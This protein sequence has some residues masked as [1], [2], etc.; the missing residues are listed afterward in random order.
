VVFEGTGASIRSFEVIKGVGAVNST[1]LLCHEGNISIK[2]SFLSSVTTA[3]DMKFALEQLPSIGEF[4][5]GRIWVW[6]KAA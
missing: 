5:Q 4:G 1:F 2:T 6:K 3:E